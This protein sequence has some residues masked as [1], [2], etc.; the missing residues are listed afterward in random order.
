MI[1][2]EIPNAGTFFKALS[3]SVLTILLTAGVSLRAF[4]QTSAEKN[5][6]TVKGVVYEEGTSKVPVEFATVQLLPQGSATTTTARGEF[7]FSKVLPG[8]T[9]I[10]V[11]F[12]G[13]EPLDTTINVIPGKNYLLEL[14]MEFSSF[15]LKEVAVVAQESKAGQATASNISRQAMDHMQVSQLADIAQ[16][17]PGAVTQ[18]QDL[19]TA[20]TITLRTLGQKDD[21]STYMNSLG[22]AII[23]DGAP[24]SNNAN[25]QT[26][27][28]TIT[29]ASGVIGGG[30]SPNQGLDLRAISTDNIESV[31][32]IRGVPSVIYGDLTSGA[33]VVKSKAGREPFT[34]RLKTDP[35]KYQ[36]SVGKGLS[37]G[38]KKG[39]LNLSADYLK[40]TNELTESYAYYERVTGRALYSNIFGKLSSNTSIDLF[41][42]KD[43]REPNPNDQRSRLS[44]GSKDVGIRFNT[45]GTWNINSWIINNLKYTLSG[46]YRDKHSYSQE[47]LGNAFA[48][49]SMSTTDGAVLSNRPGQKVYDN[50][51]N[52]LTNIPSKE[53]QYYATYLPNEYFS[54]YDIYGKE[55]NV[56]ASVNGTFS[57]KFG[58]LFSRFIAGADFK[59]DGNMGKGKVYDL[60]APPYRNVSSENSSSRPRKY[61]D[62]PFVTQVGIYG[63]ENLTLN[64]LNREMTAQ[65]GARYD[66]VQGKS[67]ISPRVN[68]SAEV[69]P[70][71][72]W[73]RGAY[74]INAKAPT[75]LYLYPE[76]AYFDLIHFN[77]I[78]SSTVPENEQLL[79][80]ST[81]VFDTQNKN[82]KIAY[83]EKF[84][85]GVDFKL[86]KMRLSATAYDEQLMDGYNLGYTADNF[87][88]IDYV[89]YE[90][91][92]VN[93]GTVPTLKQKSLNK[94]FLSYATPMNNTRSRNRG[95]EF[96]IDF[97]RIDAIRTSFIL[98][99][100]YMRTSDWSK[101]NTFV[102]KKNLNNL[103]RNIG[104]LEEANTINE[105]QRF[106]TTL[107]VV[108][109]IPSIGFVISATAQV[110][111]K[112][113]SWYTIGNDS[114]IVSYISRTDGKVYQM[115]PSKIDD[116]EFYYLKNDKDAVRFIPESY[117]PTLLMNFNITK[118]IGESLKAS[119]YANNMFNIRPLY[120]KKRYPGSYEELNIPIYFG[121]E[122]ALK[123][124]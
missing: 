16:L 106:V 110:T 84:E 78:G 103:E 13:M 104:I 22:T 24:L 3:V 67:K 30:S 87:K 76:K 120:E 51:G 17:L 122:L 113:K 112:N 75:T 63:E 61:S 118:E 95:I 99:G 71:M 28:P 82:L 105:Y 4:A 68:L 92:Q 121:F 111:W 97:G 44:T 98:S 37:L 109:N 10:K 93:A 59:T 20:K 88:L 55:V 5:F 1:K 101:G 52:E 38:D 33:I 41:I 50:N 12:M 114:T 25:M 108:H 124:K 9:E 115:D 83:N 73:I 66:N 8:K 49:Y 42:G 14:R 21:K 100:A 94:I 57:K 96:D 107:R 102:T 7:V 91:A 31:E 58:S 26:L 116:P 85:V 77:N 79:L 35:S 48:A 70:S 89:Q 53:S 18:E 65:I 2:H 29:G 23:I 72:L 43:T 45:N 117:F 40:N 90:I 46:S 36:V 123:I 56:F 119:F 27:S 86:G 34:V 69:I 74:G 6:A 54:R 32:V 60:S 81:R 62:I 80:A 39:N 47:L 19:S 64:V 15:R 11:R